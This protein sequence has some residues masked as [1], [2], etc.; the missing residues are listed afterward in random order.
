MALFHYC[1]KKSTVNSNSLNY[2]TAFHLNNKVTTGEFADIDLCLCLLVIMMHDISRGFIFHP[3]VTCK[4]CFCFSSGKASLKQKGYLISR[5]PSLQ[6]MHVIMAYTKGHF[7]TRLGI[8]RPQI[9]SIQ[10]F[11]CCLL[12][13]WWSEMPIHMHEYKEGKGSLCAISP[14]CTTL[15]LVMVVENQFI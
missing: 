15:S 14:D 8:Q 2:N 6:H 10:I 12:A 7:S 1:F 13:L 3:S 11:W 9:H 4:I 5:I